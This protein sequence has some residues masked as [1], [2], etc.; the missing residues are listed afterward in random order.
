MTLQASLYSTNCCLRA[1]LLT[2]K[3]PWAPH[4]GARFLVTTSTAGLAFRLKSMG[5]KDIQRPSIPGWGWS[6]ESKR[7]LQ[8]KPWVLRGQRQRGTDEVWVK[9]GVTR[10]EASRGS[11]ADK[12]QPEE[13]PWIAKMKKRVLSTGCCNSCP[14][15]CHKSP[16]KLMA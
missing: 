9:E 16:Q 8:T 7:I 12:K 10:G 13:I 3:G 2:K 5:P 15:P 14:L 4:P 11:R 1:P 6:H